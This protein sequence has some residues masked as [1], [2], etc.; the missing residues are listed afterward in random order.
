MKRFILKGQPLAEMRRLTCG[1]QL[2]KMRS[3]S[4]MDW[5]LNDVLQTFERPCTGTRK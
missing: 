1:I 4:R 2:P 5:L 3:A